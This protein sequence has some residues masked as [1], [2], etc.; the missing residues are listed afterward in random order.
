MSKFKDYIIIILLVICICCSVAAATKTGVIQGEQGEQGIQG[1]QG[2]Q[3]LQGIQGPQGEQG[4][5][6]IQ[7]ETGLTGAKG[8][9]G[10]KGDKGDTGEQGP[11]GK[12]GLTPYIGED[13]LWYIGTECTGVAATKTIYTSIQ[14]DVIDKVDLDWTSC[15]VGDTVAFT[16]RPFYVSSQDRGY[17]VYSYQTDSVGNKYVIHTT[18]YTIGDTTY[19][20]P[21][22]GQ[23][24]IYVFNETFAC[25]GKVVAK[26]SIGIDVEII[27]A[28]RTN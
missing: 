21:K 2:E 16:F 5:Q 20:P 11:A 4:L 7:G 24:D 10:D 27:E 1:I 9:K 12:D 17:Y 22:N 19:T 3:G 25:I 8:E 23:E 13:G 14:A 26:D 6:G 28:V 18:S 15:K